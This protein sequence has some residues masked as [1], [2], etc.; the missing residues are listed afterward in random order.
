M[1]SP[2]DLPELLS[3]VVSYLEREGLARACQ[4]SV[5]FHN[6]CTPILW[7]T[8]SHV[9][10]DADRVWSR[11]TNFREGLA[12][13]GPFVRTL[14]LDVSHFGDK[15]MELVAVNCTS[16]KSFNLST[17]YLRIETLRVLLHSDPYKTL[18]ASTANPDDNNSVDPKIRM[19][20]YRSMT[21]METGQDAASSI[22]RLIIPGRKTGG[23]SRANRLARLKGTK[24]YFPFHLEELHF[25]K[26]ID[27]SASTLFPVLSLLGPQLRCLS[28]D[29]IKNNKDPSYFIQLMKHCP[30][31]TR[32][33]RAAGAT[34]DL[35]PR[36]MEMLNLQYKQTNVN[37]LTPLIK[38]SRDKLSQLTFS[39]NHDMRDNVIYAL[40][41]DAKKANK[42]SCP[43]RSFVRN[44]V[45]S[46][47][48][49]NKSVNISHEALLD[50]FRH[51]TAL[52]MVELN[53]LDV[54]DDAMEALA[55]AS[56]NKME[57]IGLGIPEAWIQHEQGTLKH[58][59]KEQKEVMQPAA[60]ASS[61]GKKLYS[62]VWV[63]GGL[64]VLSLRKC[65]EVTN[66]GIRAIVRS[67][68]M[69]WR[70][71]L[72][73]CKC[74][75]MQVFCGPWVCNRLQDLDISGINMRSLIR[76]KSMLLEEQI[77]DERFP[78][79]PLLKTYPSDD[80][81]DNGWYDFMI[82]PIGMSGELRDGNIVDE[83][84]LVQEDEENP[85]YP[86]KNMYPAKAYRNDGETRRTLNEVYRKLGQF[87]QLIYLSMENSDY[88]IRLQD[89]LDLDVELEWFGKHFG[90]GF[91]FRADEEELERASSKDLNRV[92]KLEL[93]RV[94]EY[95]V[96][97][98]MELYD[99]FMDSGFEVDLVNMWET[100]P[101]MS[102]EE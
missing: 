24:D 32:L 17:Y 57:R 90:Y 2:L 68:P 73:D 38:A 77:E 86:S 15:V 81:T 66:R 84:G 16:L 59:V 20:Q 4:V 97:E 33:S 91:D 46:V 51:T 83:D 79:T 35:A 61:E 96:K 31:L 62:G 75:S 76:T 8:V 65:A 29:H 63:P 10:S 78:L 13:Y 43:V 44:D 34:K 60:P 80:F 74:V 9:G 45:L 87:D 53:D 94:T 19:E 5:L 52:T 69:L 1:S 18:P 85:M 27:L 55:A 36:T 7:R 70:L 21:E 12:H 102:D 49:L 89:G 25:A 67:C 47:L 28:V 50:L 88:R 37:Y 54:R 56:R 101:I 3:F 64:Q 11:D 22:V 39:D 95:S 93:L 41:E 30:N 72:R 92:S 14:R 82:L 42:V 6:A 23:Q 99:W 40:I 26:Y 100:N 58:M 98:D 71:N 48:Q